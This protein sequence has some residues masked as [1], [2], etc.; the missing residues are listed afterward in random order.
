[1]TFLIV[2]A[3]PVPLFASLS[4]TVIKN[5]FS[6]HK[7]TNSDAC[8]VFW[9]FPHPTKMPHSYKNRDKIIYKK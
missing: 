2:A 5:E 8:I 3:V 7:N 1:M 9:L 6:D 4:K